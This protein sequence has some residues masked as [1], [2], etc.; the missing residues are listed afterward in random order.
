MNMAPL[1]MH[2]LNPA[3]CVDINTNL[4]SCLRR[5][6]LQYLP[7]VFSA[8]NDRW[9]KLESL[10]AAGGDYAHIKGTTATGEEA[11]DAPVRGGP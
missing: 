11:R 10:D 3:T 6:S 4:A 1:R 9:I 5:S 2:F 8:D 7:R